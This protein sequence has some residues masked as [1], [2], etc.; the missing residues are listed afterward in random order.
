M[1]CPECGNENPAGS[2]FCMK[3]GAR[4]SQICPNC[5]AGN[6]AE[7][8]YCGQCGAS[9]VPAETRS[10][11]RRWVPYVAA[12]TGALLALAAIAVV[13]LFFGPALGWWDVPWATPTAIPPTAE[14]TLPPEPTEDDTPA[15]VEPTPDP[16]EIIATLPPPLAG[17]NFPMEA[18]EYPADWP[19]ELYYPEA[20]SLVDTSSGTLEGGAAGYGAKL[21]YQ[22][23]P[24]VAADELSL[25][26]NSKGWQIIERTELDAGGVLLLVQRDDGSG[27]GVIVLD[28]DLEIP[29]TTRGLITVFP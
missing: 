10:T 7:A 18:I 13:V 4:F 17:G 2:K 22:G 19:S 12:F 27:S 28:P 20:F 9:L 29:G 25:F 6:L 8:T 11:E 1:R 15:P 24:S 3:C 16:G 23:E 14:P 5:G 21:R 26:F